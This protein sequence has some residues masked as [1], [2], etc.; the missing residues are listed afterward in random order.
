MDSDEGDK[1]K[2]F[3]VLRKNKG[4]SAVEFAIV[5]PLFL[6]L[7]FG[8]IEFSLIL[9]A[10]AVI[11]NASREGARLGISSIYSESLTGDE[12]QIV[13]GIKDRIANDCLYSI[14]ESRLIN[15]GGPTLSKIAL[16]DKIFV[17]PPESDGSGNII[18]TVT[19]EYPYDFLLVPAFMPGIPDIITISATTKMRME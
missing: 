12:A 10:K 8:M 14:S 19:V 4:A 15:L 1:M 7:I 18:R 6:M 5:L 11:T 13:E 2:I 17:S 3:R 16:R 9:Y